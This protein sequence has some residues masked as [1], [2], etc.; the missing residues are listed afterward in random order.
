MKHFAILHLT[1]PCATTVRSEAIRR[2]GPCS[3]SGVPLDGN[4]IVRLVYID[5][6]GISK[7]AQEP[8]LV[9]AGVIVDADR[10]LHEIENEL[11]CIMMRHIPPAQ[12][13][14][15]IFHA[16]ELFNG[17]G[18]VFKRASNDLIGPYEWPLE[19]R[20]K[21][22]DEIMAIPQK[23]K[24]PIAI[25]SV[26]RANFQERVPHMSESERTVSAH[27]YCIHALRFVRRALDAQR[28]D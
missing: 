22:A 14:G 5:E 18:N 20:L 25:G 13:E 24:L 2:L 3:I 21:I 9:V 16:T 26:E 8:F 27:A 15:F 19:R 4:K 7:P 23:F 11:E 6:A 28:N 12:R 1:D 17:G 10:V